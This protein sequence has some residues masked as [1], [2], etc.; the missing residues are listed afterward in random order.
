MTTPR[1]PPLLVALV[2]ML[3]TVTPALPRLQDTHIADRFAVRDVMI[4]MRDGVRLHTKIFT[5]TAQT[6]PLP[7]IM[8]R[9]PYGVDGSA[10]NFVSYLKALA[11]E[12]YIFA[13]QDLRGK[14]GSEGTFVMQRPPRAPGNASALDEGTDTYDTIEW[15]LKNVP[16]NNGRVGML[17]ISYDGWTTIMG[18]LEP[19]PALK[20]ISPQASPADMWLGDDFHHNGAFRLSYGFE[21]AAMMESGKDV[22]QFAFDRY[23]TFGWYLALGPLSSVNARYLHGKI[24][25]WNDFVAHPDYDEFWKRQTMIPHIHEVK[26]PTLNVAGWWDQEDFYG[27]VRIYDALEEHDP[28]HLNY[29]VVGPW[30]HGG[31]SSGPGDR[32][33]AIPFDSATGKYFR[34][35]VQA[36]WFAHF[37]KDK[38]PLDMPEALTFEAGSNRWRRWDAWPPKRNTEDRPIY[39]GADRALSFDRPAAG[40]DAAFDAYVSDPAFPVPYRQR[41][42]QPTYFPGGSKWSTWLV[43]DQRFVDDRADV[44]SWKTAPLDANLTIAGEVTAHLFASTTGS[45]ADWIVKLI[46]VYPEEHPEDWDLAGYQLMVSNEVFRGR[47]RRS[48]EKPEAITPDAILEYAFSLHTQNYTFLKGHRLMVQ[49]QSTWFPIID[50]N[51]QTA[52]PNIFDATASDFRKATHRVYRSA[53][54]PSHVAIPVVVRP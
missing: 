50:R 8:K 35:S 17:G 11:D 10:G 19:H 39:F 38:G 52:V 28:S 43:E 47:Y 30:R 13:F 23:D 1:R 48:P 5:P 31:W 36:P 4:A 29:L 21:Y 7:I 26:V 3:V 25:T 54:Y 46:D 12:G 32:L 34:E 16:R 40:G 45:D 24:P 53:Q 44:L 6:A 22:Q 33:G 37:L 49:V 18:A 2:L 20:A 41:P 27:P 51:P 42:I 9:T 14:F 15:L